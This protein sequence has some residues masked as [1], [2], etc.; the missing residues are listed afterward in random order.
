M[1]IIYHLCVNEEIS[2][3]EH[4]ENYERITQTINY[5]KNKCNY[6][7]F[8]NNFDVKSIDPFNLLKHVYS[9]K[10][11][12]EL[13][14]VSYKLSLKSMITDK[15]ESMY[16]V[17]DRDTLFLPST[18]HDIFES[19]KLFIKASRDI[20]DK[21]TKYAYIITRPPGH[22]SSHNSH[23]GFCF[24]NN[25]YL[26]AK[27]LVSTYNHKGI[28]IID[29]DL[30][31]GDGTQNLIKKNNDT[32]IYFGSIHGYNGKSF[33]PGTGNVSEN[34]QYINNVPIKQYTSDDEYI[35]NFNKYMKPFIEKNIE[36]ISI[37]LISNGFDAHK[38]DYMNYLKITSKSYV[39]MTKYLKNFNYPMIYVL[40]G[41][42]NP[43]VIYESSFDILECLK[44]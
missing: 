25:I 2:S 22:H 10:Y 1:T 36:N 24:V 7:S 43:K 39:Y 28:L 21:K 27:H 4:I 40:E 30:H 34:T 38:D 12:F 33:Y 19:C 29:W 8:V 26:L 37:I 32:R 5:L 42:Y 41:G 9:D 20:Q 14:Y 17:S 35:E 3:K 11:I 15:I 31:H 44:N 23:S 13:L 18:A 16:D 6:L